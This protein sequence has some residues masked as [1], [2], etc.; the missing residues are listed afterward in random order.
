MSDKKKETP[1]IQV[2]SAE[3][4]LAAAAALLERGSGK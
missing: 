1:K 3:K 4:A 2:R